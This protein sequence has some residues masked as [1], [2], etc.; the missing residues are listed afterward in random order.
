MVQDPDE[1]RIAINHDRKE[2]WHASFRRE[3][4]MRPWVTQ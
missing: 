3:D 4:D 1:F 2:I